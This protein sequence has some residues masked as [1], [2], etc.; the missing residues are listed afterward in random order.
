MRTFWLT[1]LSSQFTF[2]KDRMTTHINGTYSTSSPL[3][4]ITIAGIKNRPHRIRLRV[5]GAKCDGSKIAWTHA[6]N[7]LRVTGLDNFFNS[8]AFESAMDLRLVY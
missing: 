7:T 4:N 3:T 5:G 8:G 1:L 2:A 6:N